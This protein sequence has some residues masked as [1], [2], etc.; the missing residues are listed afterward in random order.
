MT[1]N[2]CDARKV[3]R[4]KKQN[5]NKIKTRGVKR[6]LVRESMQHQVHTDGEKRR[7]QEDRK[8]EER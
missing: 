5:I 2:L 3:K 1:T 4:G 7:D 6:L 8:S